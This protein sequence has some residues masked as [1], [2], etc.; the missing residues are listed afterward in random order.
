[1][2]E[3]EM[4]ERLE[5]AEESKPLEAKTNY[6]AEESVS[7][8]DAFVILITFEPKL[9]PSETATARLVLEAIAN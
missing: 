9:V 3:G 2:V 1:L 6:S 7:S 4:Q 5:P 8:S